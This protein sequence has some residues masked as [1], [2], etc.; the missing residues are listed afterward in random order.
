MSCLRNGPIRLAMYSCMASVFMISAVRAQCPGPCGDVNASGSLTSADLISGVKE[1]FAVFVGV[2]QPACLDLD[3]FGGVTLRD[4]CMLS[5]HHWESIPAS[6]EC[7]PD[8]GTYVPLPNS[9]YRVYYNNV[10][11]PGD[12]IV[13]ISLYLDAETHFWGVTVSCKVHV[14]TTVPALGAMDAWPTG[15]TLFAAQKMAENSGLIH[16]ETIF[17]GG[18]TE[19]YSRGYPPR[20]PLPGRCRHHRACL[21]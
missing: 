1:S 14:D 6:I 15:E 20:S 16:G 12:T 19:F 8:S 3:D 18:W 4:F 13:R 21:E 11:P 2:D 10:F 9:A 7:E 5:G 17:S